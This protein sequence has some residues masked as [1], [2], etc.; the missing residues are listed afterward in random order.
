LRQG[1]PL[2]DVRTPK[3][4]DTVQQARAYLLPGMWTAFEREAFPILEKAMAKGV[5]R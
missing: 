3:I 4:A 5:L 2:I 1:W